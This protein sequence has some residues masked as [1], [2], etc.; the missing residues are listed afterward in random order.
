MACGAAAFAA[1][2]V[3]RVPPPQPVAG[4]PGG[5]RAGGRSKADAKLLQR[6]QEELA[7]SRGQCARLTERLERQERRMS[8][9]SASQKE[10]MSVVTE[11]N[12]YLTHNR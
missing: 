1:D 2:T 5:S 8:V 7:E 6:L 10:L 3:V 11:M 12:V 4:G 9:A